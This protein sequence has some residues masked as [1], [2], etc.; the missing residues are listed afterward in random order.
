MFKNNSIFWSILL[1]PLSVLGQVDTF[2]VDMEMVLMLA[3]EN[4]SELIIADSRL[5]SNQF[6][7]LEFQQKIK[8]RVNLN[9]ILPNLSRSIEAR[10]LPDGRD[11]FVNRS[12]MY[13]NIGLEIT[14]QIP[15]LNASWY[16]SS[17]IERL[18]VFKTSQ[19][20][21]T[22]TYFFTPI[23]FGINLNIFSF[24]ELEW[25]REEINLRNRVLSLEQ[26]E[27]RER[28]SIKALEYFSNC[29]QSQELLKITNQQIKEID[30]LILIKKR[31]NEL[32]TVSRTE[33]L[34]LQLQ[35]QNLEDNYAQIEIEFKNAKRI[36]LDYISLDYNE[37]PVQ[38]IYP[39]KWQPVSI[40]IDQV[41][42]KATQNPYLLA[43][44]KLSNR[45]LHTE[46]ERTQKNTGITITLDAS[47]GLNKSDDS[48][49]G[50]FE[51]LLDREIISA[52]FKIPIADGKPRRIKEQIIS[53][54]IYQQ[55][56]E[57]NEELKEVKR[58]AISAVEEYN[59]L[60]Q[61]IASSQSARQ[62]STE[63]YELT[64][65]QFLAGNVAYANLSLV[66]NDRNLAESSYYSTVFGAIIK[67]FEIRRMCLYDFER[68]RELSSGM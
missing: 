24:N 18:D 63:I 60:I 11:A 22:H 4:T 16:F 56:L 58:M 17:R 36:L 45:R 6:E 57:I 25:E 31:L 38:F 32:G 23:S 1:L 46:L 21:S 42:V 47:L 59:R 15:G 68:S 55:K 48:L 41:I 14:D 49:S 7:T 40:N 65:A 19:F 34:Q 27:T 39:N 28:V 29:F 62:I 35:R 13:N 66:I 53:E 26:A 20:S 50:I 54:E 67:Y 52:L 2:K 3:L 37:L 12:T 9:A 44:Q 8:P 43:R 51:G 10:P 33:I 61:R 5:K 64:R 30:N